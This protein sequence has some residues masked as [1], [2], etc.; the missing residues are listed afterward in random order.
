MGAARALR[1]NPAILVTGATGFIGKALCLDLAASGCSV[2]SAV[3]R[4]TAPAVTLAVGDIS[5]ATDWSEAVAGIECVVHLA[6]WAHVGR[7]GSEALAAARLV[8]VAGTRR[9]AEAAAAAGVRRFVFL[10]SVKV[11]G[12]STGTKPFAESDPPRPEDAYGITKWEAE[13]ALWQVAA[14][15]RMEIVVVRA[16]LVYGAG[17][18]GNFLRLAELIARG[19]PLP[20]ASVRNRRSLVYLGN[21]LDAIATCLASPRA[22]GKT[23]FVSDGEDVSTPAL[24]RAL[25]S[26][27]GA[28]AR[29]VPCPV[30]LLELAAAV[31]GRRADIGKLTGSLQVDTSRIQQDL[32]WRAPYS[33]LG[34]LQDTARWCLQRAVAE[35]RAER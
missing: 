12:E 33:F 7:G 9:L 19:V 21:L 28:P 23:Y 29:L 10:S 26:A 18:K 35:K 13:Q 6:G 5:Q 30:V 32:G 31:L 4:A 8:N 25:G 24:V 11:N 17:V 3:R 16:P 14:G 34:G 27:L 22:A 1:G 15:S 20:L 2:R